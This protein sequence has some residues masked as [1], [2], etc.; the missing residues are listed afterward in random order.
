MMVVGRII[1]GSIPDGPSW[2]CVP[3]SHPPFDPEDSRWS[4]R[5]VS[6]TSR[7]PASLARTPRSHTNRLGIRQRRLPR[8]RDPCTPTPDPRAATPDRPP[9]IHRNRPNDPCPTEQHHGSHAP[10]DDVPDRPARNLA[11]VASSTCR[12]ALDTTTH[13]QT[14]TPT[15]RPRTPTSDHP[16][17]QREPRM[18]IPTDPRRTRTARS[19]TRRVD[20]L[21]DPPHPLGSTRHAT[22]PAHRGQSSS[23]HS[24]KPFSRPTSPA[25]TPRCFADSMFC[26]SSRSPLGGCIWPGSPPTRPAPGP[27][28]PPAT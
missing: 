9:E 5:S 25:S 19:Q 11:A 16:H 8:R 13:P 22:E 15:D 27:P 23:I 6:S 3:R 4:S 1:L 12:T 14:R 7:G 28:K 20:H 21:E 10:G 17:R 26:S 24:R 18:G 2:V